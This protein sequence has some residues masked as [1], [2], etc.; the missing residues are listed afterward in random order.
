MVNTCYWRCIV[1]H[2]D[3]EIIIIFVVA[4]YVIHNYMC[5]RMTR[6]IF[7]RF[8]DTHTHTHN[9]TT[10]AVHSGRICVVIECN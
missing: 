2:T 6:S 7:V 4:F 1:V 10:V 8:V 3:T 9:V 5:F